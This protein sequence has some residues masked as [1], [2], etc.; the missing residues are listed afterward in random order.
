MGSRQGETLGLRWTYVDFDNELFHPEWQIQR[1]T[2]RHGRADPHAC[3]TK[4]YRF[5]P[6][7][8]DCRTHKSYERGCPRPE[9]SPRAVEQARP[10]PSPYP[11]NEKTP[12]RRQS[13]L[14]FQ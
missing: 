9:L 7:P 13:D 2:W 12:G 1:L 4:F 8:P 10:P 11:V 3:G 6:C 5:E 14:G